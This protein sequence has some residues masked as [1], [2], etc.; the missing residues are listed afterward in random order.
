MNLY[1]REMMSVFIINTSIR[2]FFGADRSSSEWKASEW[3]Y[4]V[5]HVAWG[6]QPWAEW[7]EHETQGSGAGYVYW[8]A[9]YEGTEIVTQGADSLCVRYMVLLYFEYYLRTGEMAK[10][11]KSTALGWIRRLIWLARLLSCHID[12]MCRTSWSHLSC[13]DL[14]KIKY[15][16]EEG[17][18]SRG[19]V[20]CC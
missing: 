5:W 14:V 9:D 10:S 20:Y 1:S 12:T 8:G 3:C 7:H 4:V 17:P 16:R 11:E 6:H 13:F 2:D 18:Y 15:F 19:T